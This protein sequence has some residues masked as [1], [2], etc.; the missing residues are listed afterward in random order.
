MNYDSLLFYGFLA[1]VIAL[2]VLRV[3]IVIMRKK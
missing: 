1:F 2:I 3:V